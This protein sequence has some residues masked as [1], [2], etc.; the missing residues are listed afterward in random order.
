[1]NQVMGIT[2]FMSL[3]FGVDNGKG[4]NHSLL[5]FYGK[6]VNINKRQMG[7]ENLQECRQ[8]GD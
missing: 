7:Q 8:E 1:M 2:Y 6:F 4:I 3:V 5:Q